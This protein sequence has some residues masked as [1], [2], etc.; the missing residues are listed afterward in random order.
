MRIGGNAELDRAAVTG[1]SFS[2]ILLF[3]GRSAT[4]STHRVGGMSGAIKIGAVYLPASN[5]ASSGNSKT[6]NDCTEL[7]GSALMVTGNSSLTSTCGTAGT[8][9]VVANEGV[10]TVEQL[11]R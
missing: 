7:I 5:F 1:G 3:G 6:S 2:G 10:E 9:D 11:T 4:T 8:S